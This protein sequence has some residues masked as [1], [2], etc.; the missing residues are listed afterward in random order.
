[1]GGPEF[2]RRNLNHEQDLL[3]NRRYFHHDK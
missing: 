2:D 3:R 1:V